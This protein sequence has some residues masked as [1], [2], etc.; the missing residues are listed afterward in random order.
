MIESVAQRGNGLRAMGRTQWAECDAQGCVGRF[1]RLG[2]LQG[3][4]DGR[5]AF[6]IGSGIVR[7]QQIH[8]IALDLVGNEF[9]DI[10]QVFT[11][12]R[13][14]DEFL[15]GP[16]LCQGDAHRKGLLLSAQRLDL[17]GGCLNFCVSEPYFRKG[18]KYGDQER[19][20]LDELFKDKD[21]KTIFSSDGLLE[22]LKKALAE[23]VLNA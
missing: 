5:T 11:L 15:V 23:R 7:T 12:S 4:S 16:R 18:A 9:E 6:I 1:E 19:D 3:R 13:E 22:K 21:P 17:I 10:G 2:A 20:F 14:L 8:Q